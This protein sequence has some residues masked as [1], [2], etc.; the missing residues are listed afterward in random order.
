MKE[1]EAGVGGKERERRVESKCKSSW[2]VTGSDQNFAF[3]RK[4]GCP[5]LPHTQA[6][7]PDTL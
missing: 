5:L 4:I 1:R 6:L 7:L 3:F 2:T